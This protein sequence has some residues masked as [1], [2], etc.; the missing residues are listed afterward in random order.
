MARKR[1]QQTSPA[2]EPIPAA[3]APLRQPADYRRLQREFVPRTDRWRF[4]SYRGFYL[5]IRTRDIAAHCE[6]VADAPLDQRTHR[7]LERARAR[8]AAP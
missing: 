4:W 1:K 3:P 8:A 7:R 6:L 2:A 5:C